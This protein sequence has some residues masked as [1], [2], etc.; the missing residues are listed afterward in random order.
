MIKTVSKNDRPKV[1]KQN[2]PLGVAEQYRPHARYLPAEQMPAFQPNII[3]LT[4]GDVPGECRCTWVARHG[5]RVVWELKFL[6]AL[7]PVKHAA[8]DT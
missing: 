7:C 1:N 8:L 5:T 4:I 6:Y 2:K 3:A